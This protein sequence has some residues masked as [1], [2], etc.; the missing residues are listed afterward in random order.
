MVYLSL[1]RKIPRAGKHKAL[2][3]KWTISELRLVFNLFR[4]K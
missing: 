4:Y 3:N 2:L 1:S